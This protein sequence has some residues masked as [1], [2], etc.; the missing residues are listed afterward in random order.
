MTEKAGDTK[1]APP[2]NENANQPQR[3]KDNIRDEQTTAEPEKNIVAASIAR[4]ESHTPSA[5]VQSESERKTE[6]VQIETHRP[7]NT[8]K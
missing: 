4:Q 8:N 3:P 6:L 7:A 5:P 1:S 2:T